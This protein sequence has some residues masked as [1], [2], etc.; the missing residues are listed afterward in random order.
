MTR[1]YSCA[2]QSFDLWTEYP[3]QETI[4]ESII[5]E[6]RPLAPVEFNKATEFEIQSSP[7][8]YIL[9]DRSYYEQKIRIDI[10]KLDG[11][12]ITYD[13]WAKVSIVN[14]FLPST[15]SQIKMEI[16]NNTMPDSQDTYSYKAYFENLL[17]FDETAKKSHLSSIIWTKDISGKMDEL[18]TERA[19]YLSPAKLTE[20]GKGN[21][22]E[23][24]G[25][26]HID[27][28]F[29]GRA[30]LGGSKIRFRYFHQKPEFFLMIKDQNIVP[31]VYIESA[32]MYIR[33]ARVNPSILAA[34]EAALKIRPAQYPMVAGVVKR[35]VLKK[36]TVDAII[37]NVVVGPQPN[38]IFVAFVENDAFN[39]SLK[40]NPYNFKLF[41]ISY[42]CFYRN[43]QSFPSIP[44]TPDVQHGKTLREYYSFMDAANQLGTSN[45]IDIN[46]KE[47]AQ[48]YGIFG[49]NF[50]PDLSDG[51]GMDGHL[52][53][54]KT[55]SSRLQVI[56]KTPLPSAVTVLMYCEFQTTLQIDSDRNP[57]VTYNDV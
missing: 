49:V 48:G 15:I 18:N 56:F 43:G 11:T 40:K 54:I 47:W 42:L 32:V 34:H 19:K 27:I 8:E 53:H 36:D 45:F 31:K 51:C 20:K 3:V 55:G 39:G 30:F 26:Q 21:T 29:Q 24:I 16:A 13:D 5:T 4:Q 46:R 41:D 10:S 12:S 25:K 50:T 6:H 9:F 52:N 14:N 23:L 2:L 17:G 37:E 57:I 28:A 22:I 7:D 44:F 35:A 38:R 1:N 33:R